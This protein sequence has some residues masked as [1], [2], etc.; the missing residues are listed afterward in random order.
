VQPGAA[1]GTEPA[2][3]QTPEQSPDLAALLEAGAMDPIL[4]QLMLG[5]PRLPVELERFVRDL[6]QKAGQAVDQHLVRAVH[7]LAGTL[8]MAPVGQEAE[9]ARALEDYLDDRLKND[10]PVTQQALFT[11]QT[12]L[13][14]FHQ[15]VAVRSIC[16]QPPRRDEH[17]SPS[18]PGWLRGF[19]LVPALNELP[20]ASRELAAVVPAPVRAGEPVTLAA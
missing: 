18:W 5:D 11:M 20:S 16:H 4:R 15:R 3:R 17:C 13:H 2:D 9:V 14:R 19:R 12:C 10:H 1:A 7:T 6:A 8:S